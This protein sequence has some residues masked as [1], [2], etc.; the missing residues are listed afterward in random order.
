MLTRFCSFAYGKSN[1]N[2]KKLWVWSGAEVHISCRS[3]RMLQNKN[4]LANIGVGTAENEPFWSFALR[5]GR[6]SSP[7][8]KLKSRVR[9]LTQGA[10]F[11]NLQHTHWRRSTS[12]N[13]T[14][15][16]LFIKQDKQPFLPDVSWSRRHLPKW[17]NS[18]ASLMQPGLSSAGKDHLLD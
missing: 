13:K 10:S 11:W 2:C 6:G 16:A 1:R 5:V 14:V 15:G 9:I 18:V 17:A 4:L 12:V 3:S 8:V 7:S